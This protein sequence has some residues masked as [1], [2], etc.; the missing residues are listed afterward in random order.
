MHSISKCNIFSATF[1]FLRQKK[2]LISFHWIH[3][4]EWATDDIQRQTVWKKL[5]TLHR[6][7]HGIQLRFRQR[8]YIWWTPMAAPMVC[9]CHLVSILAY[10]TTFYVNRCHFYSLLIFVVLCASLRFLNFEYMSVVFV[11]TS[12]GHVKMFAMSIDLCLNIYHLVR[13]RALIVV[14]W[15]TISCKKGRSSLLSLRCR[16]VRHVA[17]NARY[18]HRLSSRLS[19]S[20]KPMTATVT[21]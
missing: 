13:W 10:V 6:K 2:K 16:M 4:N 14:S 8:F 12:E 1:F 15:T 9:A 5:I 21:D 19:T 17:T 18:T 11:C 3:P 20:L 7:M